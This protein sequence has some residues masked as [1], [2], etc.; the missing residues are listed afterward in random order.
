M[1]RPDVLIIGAG[2]IGLTL[3]YELLKRGQTI[4][5]LD[6]STAGQGATRAA[7]GM[8]ATDE[9]LPESLHELAALSRTLYPDIGQEIV[10]RDGSR[11]WLSGTAVLPATRKSI[12]DA[13]TSRT[14]RFAINDAGFTESD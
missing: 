13:R 4:R 2:I 9:E 10:G 1:T 3:G 5:L 8:L 7:A 14:D 12:L 6:Q 11:E